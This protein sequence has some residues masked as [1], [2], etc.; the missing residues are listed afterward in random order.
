MK[1]S[2]FCVISHTHW[3]RE[4][5]MPLELMRLRLVDLID[6]CLK[7]LEEEPTYVFHLDAQTVVLEDYLTIRTDRRAELEKYILDGRLS[8]GPWYLQ[9]DYYLTSGEATVRNLLEGK[10]LAD[11]FGKCGT[12]GYAPDQ[13]GNISQLPQILQGFG[14]DNFVFGRG[15]CKLVKQEDGSYQRVPFPS[16]FIWEGAD[17]SRLLAVHMSHWYNNAQRLSSD[18]DKAEKLV[19]AIENSFE[20]IAATPYLLLM[21]GVD[22]LEAQDDLMPVLE[23][24]R[25]RGKDIR[26]MRMDEYID[27]VKSYVAE[28]DLPLE[29]YVGE[30][31]GGSDGELLKGTLSS[32]VYLKQW[33]VLLQNRLEQRLEPLYTMLSLAG[34]DEAYPRQHF[35][36]MWKELMKNHP[37]D[38]ICGCSRDEVHKHMEDN[39]ERLDEMSTEMLRRGMD[40][41]A[42]HISLVDDDLA[43]YGILVANT[44]ADERNDRVHATV[45]L[46]KSEE[47][48]GFTILDP[49]GKEVPYRIVS[50]R[51]TQR[52]VFS[53]INLPGKIAVDRY[54]VEFIADHLP[55]FSFRAYTVKRSEVAVEVTPM[56]CEEAKKVQLENRFLTITVNEKGEVD[57]L[58]KASGRLMKNCLDWED[59]PDR[60]D[61]YV[62]QSGGHPAIYGSEFP[63]DKITVTDKDPMHQSVTIRRI[64]ELPAGYDFEN[65]VRTAETVSCPVAMTISL[66]ETSEVAEISYEIE[67]HAKNHRLRLLVRTGIESDVTAADIPF[68]LIRHGKEDYVK[69]VD[70]ASKV[71]PNTSFAALETAEGGTAVLTTGQHEYEHLGDTLAF[72]VLRATGIISGSNLPATQSDQWLAPGNQCIRT[73]TGRIGVYPYVGNLLETVPAKALAFTTPLSTYFFSA[74]SKKF[75]G[76]R[77]AVQDTSIAE[78]FYLPDPFPGMKLCSDQSFVTLDRTPGVTVTA[79]KAADR[80]GGYILRMLNLNQEEATVTVHTDRKV[81]RTPLSEE[82]DQ[83]ID[84]ANIPMRKK[85][86]LTLRLERRS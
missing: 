39:F 19:D 82:S 21:N 44:T 58:H 48:F 51:D 11:S 75:I 57:L 4:W 1:P 71:L 47:F 17:G 40:L 22:H 35:R 9:N 72:T 30:L 54:E 55:G 33:N 29:T 13:F 42:N 62:Y 60:Y 36:Y 64:M 49:A 41:A 53:P 67:N 6:R 15:A 37:H 7:L 56:I 16:E 76:G 73:L 68:D 12:V 24:L 61:S 86:L 78:F 14:I 45:D 18:I 74:D 79:F 81:S 28:N 10:K 27:A 50:K 52:D 80:R 25:G 69:Y 85:E 70:T 20:G 23:S 77:P 38:S 46:P 59:T 65:E 32:R 84:I 2:I 83:L 31:R 34:G 63:V 8:V 3:D 26:Q 43:N 66:D 5:Y